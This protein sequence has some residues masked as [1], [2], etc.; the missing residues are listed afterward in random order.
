MGWVPDAKVAKHPGGT[1]SYTLSPLTSPGGTLY[2]VQVP[3]AVHRTY[4]IEFRQA[5]GFDAGLPASATNGAIIHLGGLMHQPD[6]SE[7]GCWD[8]CFLDMVPATSTMSDGAL[9]VP[10]AFVDSQTGVT[11]TAVS[12]G[13]GG[14]DGVGR[15]PAD[16][17]R[18][19]TLSQAAA[20]GAPVYKFFL[21]YG[22][23][24]RRTRRFHSAWPATFRW[25]AI[26]RTTG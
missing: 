12:K 8:T 19:G 23:L 15:E 21:D 10:N 17:R 11:I 4:W 25:S 20:S 5:T 13:A 18:P 14:L 16:A 7:Y 1:A 6:R 24:T 9:A 2:A 22:S 26:S 3:A